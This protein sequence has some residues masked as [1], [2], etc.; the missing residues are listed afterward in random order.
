M[1]TSSAVVGSSASSSFG[2]VSRAVPIRPAAA[3][4]RTAHAGTA[5]A[6]GHHRICRPRCGKLLPDGTYLTRL[7]WRGQSMKARVVE[8]RIDFLT[9]LPA[10]HSLLTSPDAGATITVINDDGQPAAVAGLVTVQVSQTFTLITSLLDTGAY[11]RRRHRRPVRRPVDNRIG[12]LR[13]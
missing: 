2:E 4:R 13:T 6:A 7:T 11:P 1:V 3:C 12:L 9:Q 8:F 10:G 5:A